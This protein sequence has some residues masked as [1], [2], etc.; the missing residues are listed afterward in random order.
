M[1]SLFLQMLDNEHGVELFISILMS[2]NDDF[3]SQPWTDR[4]QARLILNNAMKE[5]MNNP[6]RDRALNYCQQLWNLLPDPKAA[7]KRDDILR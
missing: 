7:G 1:A 3:D 2:F 4:S 6:S 5:V